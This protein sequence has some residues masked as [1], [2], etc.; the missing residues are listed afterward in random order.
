M[1]V[2]LCYADDKMA[3]IA[4][5]GRSTDENG[6]IIAEDFKKFMRIN[7]NVIVAFAGVA[8]AGL[9]V[10]NLLKNPEKRNLVS[11]LYVKDIADF[12]KMCSLSFPS[13]VY[14]GYIIAGISRDKKICVATA[15]TYQETQIFYPKK[16]APLYT[17]IFPKEMPKSNHIFE[18]FLSKE[19]KPIDAMKQTIKYCSKLSPSVNAYMNYDI[20]HLSLE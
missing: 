11:Q 12:I 18:D 14:C 4:S 3:I 2:V 17:G 16:E 5:D 13:D 9:D 7:D 20:I 1:S 15:A 10:C 8:E 6:K 19:K